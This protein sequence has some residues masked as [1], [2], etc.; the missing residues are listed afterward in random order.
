MKTRGY[1]Q[2]IN[3]SSDS[4]K[5]TTTKFLAN[6]ECGNAVS[7]LDNVALANAIDFGQR[8]RNNFPVAESDNFNMNPAPIMEQPA[9]R[10][11]RHIRSLRHDR[12]GHDL[13][14]GTELSNRMDV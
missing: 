5:D 1:G 9:H 11:H 2:A 12:I 10:S 4:I 7:C 13:F 8:H 3:G 14:N 6:A